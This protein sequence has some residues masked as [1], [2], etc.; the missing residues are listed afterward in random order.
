MLEFPHVPLY[1]HWLTDK[2]RKNRILKG[3]WV[4]S[5]YSLTVLL[6][7]L[8]LQ[9]WRYYLFE[10]C[11]FTGHCAMTFPFQWCRYFCVWNNMIVS[12]PH[13]IRTWFQM[14]WRICV[15][16]DKSGYIPGTNFIPATPLIIISSVT[17][18]DHMIEIC[19]CVYMCVWEWEMISS[20]EW[21]GSG[22]VIAGW[23]C[24]LCHCHL[25]PHNSVLQTPHQ[26]K[27]GCRPL[28]LPVTVTRR[29]S[30]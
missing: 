12:S 13:Q 6:Q 29:V 7:G 27:D 18:L 10:K 3:P 1:V 22:W 16:R 9:W 21:T 8:F 5:Y 23:R 30:V 11:C 20:A 24:V 26:P 4:K 15:S 14:K 17:S 2:V 25:T 19:V 28:R